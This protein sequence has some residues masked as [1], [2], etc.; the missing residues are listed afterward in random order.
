MP[1]MTSTR[2]DHHLVFVFLVPKFFTLCTFNFPSFHPVLISHLYCFSVRS[3]ENLSSQT[4]PPKARLR[5]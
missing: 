1:V 3:A 2:L 4:V 5:S